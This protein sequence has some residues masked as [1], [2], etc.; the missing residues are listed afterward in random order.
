MASPSLLLPDARNR[1]ATA[2]QDEADYRDENVYSAIVVANTGAGTQRVFSGVTGQAI[3]ELGGTSV[4]TANAHQTKYSDLTTNLVK[5]GELAASLGDGAV[6]AIGVTFETAAVVSTTGKARSFGMTQ[7]EVND[8]LSKLSFEFK[9]SAKRQIIGALHMFPS[10]GGITGGLSTTGNSETAS[11]AQNGWPGTLRRL[12]LPIEIARNDT[13]E[14]I[15]TVGNGATLA[16]NS[17]SAGTDGQ[18][19]LV[20]VNLLCNIQGD[21]R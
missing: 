2:S 4:A 15:F 13:I 17:D 14:G 3:P 18:P 7:F 16:F 20:W 1:S 6:R 10:G 21:V 11:M 9:V 19:S 5:P 8:C 12:K